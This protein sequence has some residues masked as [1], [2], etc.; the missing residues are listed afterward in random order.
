[1]SPE[2]GSNRWLSWTQVSGHRV[3]EKPIP[4][5]PQR[6]SIW[7][8]DLWRHIVIW[9][10]L[11]FGVRPSYLRLTFLFAKHYTVIQNKM[12]IKLLPLLLP[13]LLFL[14]VSLTMS[15]Y[16]SPSC[17][18]LWLFLLPMS[19]VLIIWSL[20]MGLLLFGSPILSHTTQMKWLFLW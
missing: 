4:G 5:N 7:T 6:P 11:T 1:M 17:S 9:T 13:F 15:V 12:Y 2:S 3:K 18:F 14:Y 10:M 19:W 20:N 8:N 16:F